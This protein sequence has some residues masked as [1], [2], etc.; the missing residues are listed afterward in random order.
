MAIRKKICDCGYKNTNTEAGS[1]LCTSSS[2]PPQ[3]WW[4][5]VYG[6]SL[7]IAGFHQP[8]HFE[9]WTTWT[10]HIW[11]SE[12]R[13]CGAFQPPPFPCMPLSIGMHGKKCVLGSRTTVDIQITTNPVLS[14]TAQR[15]F[16]RDLLYQVVRTPESA[17]NDF[18]LPVDQK[19]GFDWHFAKYNRIC[20]PSWMGAWQHVSCKPSM[21]L[22]TWYTP[23]PWALG[24]NPHS[25]FVVFFKSE[26]IHIFIYIYIHTYIY[27]YIYTYV[28]HIYTC[29]FLAKCWFL[30]PAIPFFKKKLTKQRREAI[31]KFQ[32]RKGLKIVRK[33]KNGSVLLGAFEQYIYPSSSSCND[34]IVVALKSG[35]HLKNWGQEHE[36]WKQLEPI[37]WLSPG[38]SF[39]VKRVW[40]LDPQTHYCRYWSCG[41]FWWAVSVKP[42][43][44][45][46][47]V[48]MYI[49]IKSDMFRS[50]ASQGEQFQAPYSSTSLQ[51]GRQ[52]PIIP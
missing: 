52:P 37:R 44:F 7:F 19:K 51:Q 45:L 18:L 9:T 14:G 4:A 11:W 42:F 35:I 43:R 28:Y 34:C 24:P 32:K 41:V 49:I 3:S 20:R 6:N 36:I 30:R 17:S 38:M 10:W 12:F 25:Q 39:P 5:S 22:G 8:S 26:Y 50:L 16:A 13:L 33:S 48:Y 31:R 2:A 46:A 27:I 40:W 23:Q 21:L 15:P 47:D 1:S 29:P